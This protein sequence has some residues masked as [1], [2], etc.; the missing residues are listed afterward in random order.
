MLHALADHAVTRALDVG[1]LYRDGFGDR[2]ALARLVDDIAAYTRARPTGEIAL[3]DL[4]RPRTVPGGIVRVATFESPAATPLPAASRTG[5][6]ELWTPSPR[7]TPGALC[8]VLASTGEEGFLRRRP[9]AQRLL[10]E[11]IASVLLEN[12]YYGA[13]RPAG[14]RGPALRTVFDQLAMSTATVDETRALLAWARATGYFPGVAGYSHGGMM[15]AFAAALV[16][17]PVVAVPRATGTHAAPVLADWPLRRLV[18]WKSLAREAGSRHAA[19][20]ELRRT[21]H[22]VDLRRHPGPVAPE[23]ATVVV[24]RHDRI[25]PLHSSLELHAHW[26]GSQ[27]VVSDVGHMTSALFDTDV[28]ARA[29]VDAFGR[30]LT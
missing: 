23:L 15:G 27:L 13:R 17:F 3:R 14:Q 10:R 9:F 12:P 26:K 24:A 21:L 11:G 8:V 5:R 30:A 16:D 4:S 20:A 2:D 29:V 28:H 1:L 25:F 22:P 18:H 19:R 6:I 7:R